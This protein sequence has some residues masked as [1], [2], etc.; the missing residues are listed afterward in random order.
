MQDVKKEKNANSIYNAMCEVLD[1][2]KLSY[3]KKE[4]KRVVLFS[5]TDDD[6]TTEYVISVDAER[7]MIR[8]MLMLPVTFE[9]DRKVDGAIATSALNYSIVDGTFEFT[10]EDGTVWFRI[11]TPFKDSILSKTLLRYLLLCAASTVG[12]VATNLFLLSKGAMSLEDFME[13]L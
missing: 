10:Y 5:M 3:D 13:K 6:L 1:E 4:E 12:K 11:G 7:E 2:F 8:L 9:K